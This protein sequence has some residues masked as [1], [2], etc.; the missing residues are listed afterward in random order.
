MTTPANPPADLAAFIR[1]QLDDDERIATDNG[2]L[3]PAWWNAL[4]ADARNRSEV[5][6]AGGT[7]IAEPMAEWDAKHIARHNPAR[8]AAEVEAKRR[9]LDELWDHDAGLA[10]EHTAPRTAHA[11]LRL[12]ALPFAG[13]PGFREEWKP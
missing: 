5:V 9:I 8:V 13:R 1:A 6:T 2:R 10:T 7:L 4:P 11:V 3:R 12:L